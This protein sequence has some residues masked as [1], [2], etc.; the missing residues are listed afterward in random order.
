MRPLPCESAIELYPAGSRRE[1]TSLRGLPR[2]THAAGEAMKSGGGDS[3][4]EQE[5]RSRTQWLMLVERYTAMAMMLPAATFVGYGMGYLL[6]RWLHQKFFTMIFLL[7]GIAAGL[8]QFIRQALK[9]S[10]D[11]ANR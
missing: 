2:A 11:D 1:G 4:Q 10:G 9:D 5:K 3:A 7:L 8:T 6:D